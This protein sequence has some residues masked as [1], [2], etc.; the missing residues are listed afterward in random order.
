VLVF[1]LYIT[2]DHREGDNGLCFFTGGPVIN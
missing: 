2:Y 1:H